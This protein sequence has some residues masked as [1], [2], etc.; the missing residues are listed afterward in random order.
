MLGVT[1][2]DGGRKEA[3]LMATVMNTPAALRASAFRG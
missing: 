1:S 2:G 3:L